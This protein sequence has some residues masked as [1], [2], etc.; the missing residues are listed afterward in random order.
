MYGSI[1][2]SRTAWR[3][4]ALIHYWLEFIKWYTLSRGNLGS[5]F[6][7][8]KNVPTLDPPNNN[9]PKGII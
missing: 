4:G 3:G 8:L 6:R 9:T 7:S 1:V 2:R 5:F